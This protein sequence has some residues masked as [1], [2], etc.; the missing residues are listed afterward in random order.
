[1]SDK[2]VVKEENGKKQDPA[3]V[4]K[5]TWDTWIA[6]QAENVQRLYNSHIKGLKNTITATRGERDTMAGELREAAAK[7]D[8]GSE[9]ET[10]LTEMAGKFEAME[11]RAIFA[12][13]AMKPEIGCTNSHAAYL[14][15][16]ADNLFD[17]KGSPA[18]DAIKKAA[19]ELFKAASANANAGSG[20]DQEPPAT[21]DMNKAIRQ[22]TGRI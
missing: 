22:A 8:K 4:T 11:K 6:D 13:E 2:P 10:K 19:P 5:P 9:A 16:Q 14:V 21:F 15:A 3:V 20:T 7:L 12:E 18:W 1:M 17:R